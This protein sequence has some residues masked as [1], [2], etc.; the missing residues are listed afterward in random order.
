M[1]DPSSLRGHLLRFVSLAPGRVDH[2]PA[3]R[4]AIGLAIPLTVLLV[5][6]QITWAMYAGF[7]AFTGIYSRYEPTRVR[8]RR[9][10]LIGTLLTLC[11]TL[12]AAL[13]ELGASIPDPAASWVSLVIA[14]LVAGG[15]ATLVTARGIRPG[16]AVF[17]LFA[18]AAVAAAPPAAPVWAAALA[19]G[20]RSEE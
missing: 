19:A 15:A 3:F 20:L 5:T 12:G 17:P 2:V 4:I 16:G 10:A 1:P 13:A 18:V 11:V 14:A 7:G 9:Q 8:L 6:D